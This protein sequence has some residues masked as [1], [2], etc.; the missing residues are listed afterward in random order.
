[1]HGGEHGRPGPAHGQQ[2]PIL[3]A[4]TNKERLRTAPG[5]ALGPRTAQFTAHPHPTAPGASRWVCEGRVI[6][7]TVQKR[8]LKPFRA[9]TGLG[10]PWPLGHTRPITY[11]CKSSFTGSSVQVFCGHFPAAVAELSHC[12]REHVACKAEGISCL[13]LCREICRPLMQPL[14]GGS[15]TGTRVSGCLRRL[16]RRAGQ[17]LLAGWGGLWSWLCH[18]WPLDPR[19]WPDLEA[20]LCFHLRSWVKDSA[21]VLGRVRGFKTIRRVASRRR[22]W[23]IVLCLS[24]QLLLPQLP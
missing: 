18:S 21:H 5:P 24:L 8:K 7:P 6:V 14:R 2:E 9:G 11:F 23:V 10:K 19:Q 3:A 17:P 4:V 22:W 1:M 15:R 20:C 16:L 13:A 12:N